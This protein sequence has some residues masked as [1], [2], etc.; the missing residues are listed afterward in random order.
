MRGVVVDQIVHVVR[1]QARAASLPGGNKAGEP[2]HAVGVAERHQHRAA[3]GDDADVAGAERLREQGR[4]T[5]RCLSVI[6]A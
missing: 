3:L 2:G 6:L 4:C 5:C 1:R